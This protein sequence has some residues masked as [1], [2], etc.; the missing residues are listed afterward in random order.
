MIC[1]VI[2][3]LTQQPESSNDES[4]MLNS[5]DENNVT[6]DMQLSRSEK[7]KS[8]S[9]KFKPGQCRTQFNFVT[10]CEVDRRSFGSSSTETD[11]ETLVVTVRHQKE[12]VS[13][14]SM[15]INDAV[16]DKVASNPLVRQ[17]ST[18]SRNSQDQSSSAKAIESCSRLG[19]DLLKL[20]VEQLRTDC[21]IRVDGREFRAHKCIL[22][23]R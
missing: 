18:K 13:M 15:E 3:G 19:K 23:S 21:V 16:S 11:S 7:R 20:F 12:P 5:I 10:N 22:A 14:S 6:E 2:N 1:S 17:Q 9:N 8:N 4:S